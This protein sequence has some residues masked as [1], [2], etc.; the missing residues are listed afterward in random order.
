MLRKFSNVL[1]H[2]KRL[3]YLFHSQ[4]VKFFDAGKYMNNVHSSMLKNGRTS[5]VYTYSAS[6]EKKAQ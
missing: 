5:Y 3:D 1:V 6:H 2:V 4:T